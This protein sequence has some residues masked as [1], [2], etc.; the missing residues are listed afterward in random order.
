MKYF[1]LIVCV[2]SLNNLF[3]QAFKGLPTENSS[4]VIIE[5]QGPFTNI[6]YEY[7]IVGDT[8]IFNY[9]YFILSTNFGDQ[10]IRNDSASK[11]VKIRQPWSYFEYTLYDFS[12][13]QGDTVFDVLFELSHLQNL[14]VL[15]VDSINISNT[16]YKRMYLENYSGFPIVWIDY[17]GCVSSSIFNSLPSVSYTYQ[18][19]CFIYDDNFYRVITSDSVEQT[20][21]CITENASITT[22]QLQKIELYPNPTTTQINFKGVNSSSTLIVYN[23]F[24]QAVLN[25]KINANSTQTNISNLPSGIYFVTLQNENNAVIFKQKMVK[26]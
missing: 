3:S 17:F 25:K 19:K 15:N 20:N 10:Y 21:E 6:E 24:G 8:L 13:Q 23:S 16:Y 9:D 4:W 5:N 11:Q 18:A 26:L 7:Q 14:I 22:T 2:I 1:S 12:K